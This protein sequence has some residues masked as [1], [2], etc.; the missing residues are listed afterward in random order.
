[1]HGRIQQRAERQQRRERAAE[2]LAE[3]AAI[4]DDLEIFWVFCHIS[5]F[6]LGGSLVGATGVAVQ[7]PRGVARLLL[8]AL[9]G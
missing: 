6:A 1:M 9:D 4:L 7:D 5:T 3:V 2:V 8:L